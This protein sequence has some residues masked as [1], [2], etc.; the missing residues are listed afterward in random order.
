MPIVE[1]EDQTRS[2]VS[3]SPSNGIKS[4]SENYLSANPSSKLYGDVHYYM[5]GDV[6]N[7]TMY[8][9]AKFV[10]EFGFQSW[11]S[12]HTMEYSLETK[13]LKFP[14]DE[15]FKHREH[16]ADWLDN[17]TKMMQRYIP[18]ATP[19][20]VR[21]L[22]AYIY[23]TQIFQ[24]MAIKTETEFYRRNRALKDNG[25][26]YTMGALYWQLNDIWPTVSWASTEFGG[27][28]KMLHYYVKN[29]F[30]NLLG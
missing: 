17:M 11:S 23:T 15:A 3:S 10:S 2:Y 21:H 1:E 4:K 6:W 24:A 9:S 20:D 27:K 14:L 25:E 22:E 13:H 7:W 30:E 19:C 26:G 18:L 5:M 12:L 28:W 16:S 8:P 29:M